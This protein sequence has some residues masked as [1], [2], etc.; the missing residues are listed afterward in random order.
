MYLL[1][2]ALSVILLTFLLQFFLPPL[3]PFLWQ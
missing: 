1:D 2:A 3:Q